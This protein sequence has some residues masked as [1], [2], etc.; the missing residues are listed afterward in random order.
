[1]AVNVQREAVHRTVVERV[2]AVAKLRSIGERRD[3]G[4]MFPLQSNPAA[5]SARSTL[6]RSIAVD[7][8][9]AIIPPNTA[10]YSLL[11]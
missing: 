6:R 10:Q 4:T 2:W 1:M 3:E 7:S 11:Q 9:W 8:T 5:S